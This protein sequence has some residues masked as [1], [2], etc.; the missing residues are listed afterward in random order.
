VGSPKWGWTAGGSQV[1]QPRTGCARRWA[2][3]WVLRADQCTLAGGKIGSNLVKI[4]MSAPGPRRRASRDVVGG[5]CCPDC[6]AVLVADNTARLCNRCHKARRDELSSPPVLKD[7]FYKTD[8]FRAASAS[9][10]I[11]KV[12]RAYRNHPHWLR[13]FGKALNQELFGGWLRLSQERV[14]KIENAPFGK[15]E[16]NLGTLENYAIILHLPQ[17]IL[18]FDLPGQ[19]RLDPPKLLR[20]TGDLVVPAVRDGAV[21]AATGLDSFGVITLGQHRDVRGPAAAGHGSMLVR[22]ELLAHYES[23]T[24]NYRQIDYQ[25]GARAVY[26]L[27][28]RYRTACGLAR[29]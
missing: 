19:S 18:W 27:A 10:H 1:T 8:E 26:G 6:G 22:P 21:V 28:R 14:S 3:G 13:I 20:A 12:F 15:R 2:C 9:R 11:G 25:A 16:Q 24:D 17:H 4:E 23:L 5:R 7:E 29:D